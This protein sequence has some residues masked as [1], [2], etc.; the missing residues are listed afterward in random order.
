MIRVNIS[1]L[2]G[3]EFI[4]IPQNEKFI[5]AAAPCF[6]CEARGGSYCETVLLHGLC[7]T[8]K[9]LKRTGNRVPRRSE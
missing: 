2:G 8:G 5:K 4:N 9:I 1:V 7:K 6:G 3:V